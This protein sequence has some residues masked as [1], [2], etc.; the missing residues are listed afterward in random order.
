MNRQQKYRAW[1]S[2][3]KEML[4]PGDDTALLIDY[5]NNQDGEI[6]EFGK[7]VNGEIVN[8]ASGACGDVLMQSTGLYDT[9]GDEIYEGDIVSEDGNGQYKVEY[10]GGIY[11]LSC[12]RGRPW[13]ELGEIQIIGNIY[14]GCEWVEEL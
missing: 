5:F 13:H 12:Y 14:E 7:V 1:K 10:N 3:T 2:D 6:F 8:G 9:F 11:S 4:Y